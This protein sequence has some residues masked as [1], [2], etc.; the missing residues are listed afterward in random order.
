MRDSDQLVPMLSEL[1]PFLDKGIS[2]NET[3]YKQVIAVSAQP[4]NVNDVQ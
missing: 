2:A 4:F 3:T 1:A